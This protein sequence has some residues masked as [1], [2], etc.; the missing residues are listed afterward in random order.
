MAREKAMKEYFD[1]S[2]RSAP[3]VQS[4]SSSTLG[5]KFLNG[6]DALSHI[7][8]TIFANWEV[9]DFPAR[10][11]ISLAA[12]RPRIGAIIEANVARDDDGQPNLYRGYTCVAFTD[13]AV[14]SRNAS[15][16][17]NAGGK[18]KGDIWLQ[19]GSYKVPPDPAIL[20]YSFFRAALLSIN[21]IWSPPWNCAQVFRLGYYN[22][23]L[24]PG[25]SL[26]PYS[27]FHIP[28]IAYLSASLAAKVVAPADI[29]NERTPDG[30]LL[31]SAT[32]DR[33]DPTNPEH[34]RR[35]R[36]LAEIMIAET[37]Y[38]PGGTTRV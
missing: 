28:W 25:A 5:A 38:Q 23:P 15:L 1:Y 26:F 24:F 12:A 35:A 19:T 16:R 27:L 33:L 37:G 20:T 31:M 22:A 14:K 21:A 10:T 13:N 6:L 34:L 11:S 17:V 3:P 32:T 4:E 36:I 7:D 9:M 8:P 2:I 18:V 30:G 29:L